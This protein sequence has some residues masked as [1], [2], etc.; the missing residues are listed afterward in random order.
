MF[1]LEGGTP[2]YESAATMSIVTLK[3]DVC[4]NQVQK[5]IAH[6][7][8]NS[9]CPR[10]NSKTTATVTMQVSVPA[11]AAA[12]ATQPQQQQSQQGQQQ[13][14]QVQQ[15]P[16]INADPD[17]RAIVQNVMRQTSGA[18][19]VAS[20]PAQLSQLQPVQP[21]QLQAGQTVTVAAPAVAQ[22]LP[23]VQLPLEPLP[24]Q[25]TSVQTHL[26]QLQPQP[27]QVSQGQPVLD[28]KLQNVVQQVM[29]TG[30]TSGG[31]STAGDM[32]PP[33][34]VFMSLTPVAPQQLVTSPGGTTI[35][36]Q[37]QPPN[38]V[39]TAAPPAIQLPQHPLPVAQAIAQA[40]SPATTVT[41]T[42]IDIQSQLQNLQPIPQAVI[43][44]SMSNAG[45]AAGA[46]GQ[47]KNLTCD[48][49]T[50]NST[51][52]IR[53]S[54]FIIQGRRRGGRRSERTRQ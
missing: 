15:I 36:V 12:A 26:Q 27:P 42:T 33:P 49:C 31:G 3:C 34:E 41:V 16:R 44:N 28:L 29:T 10:C 21:H 11:A 40:P 51:D 32:R 24:P 2:D 53:V 13:A 35:T 37:R 23:P 5:P 8:D 48:R 47:G 6:W 39:T 19:T 1:V 54:V 50:F 43:V 52:Q 9:L 17:V 46:R 22:Q 25:Q 7:N 30:K 20:V 18:V 4:S 38:V 14:V 45:T